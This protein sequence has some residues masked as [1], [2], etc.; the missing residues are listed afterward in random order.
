MKHVGF[1]GTGLIGNP[2]ARRLVGCGFSVRAH[3]RNPQALE[4][5]L[6]A[7]AQR[8]RAPE[9][10]RGVEALLI[11]VNTLEQVRDVLTGEAGLPSALEGGSMP[12]FV[13][14]STV[15]PEGILALAEPLRVRGARLLDAPVSGGPFLAELGRL[16][17]M[18]GGAEEAFQQVRPV[19]EALGD[20][21]F[22]V[23]PLGAGMSAKLVNNMIGLAS[24]LVVPEA[25][26]IGVRAGLNVDRL[27][28]ILNAG[29]GKSFIT[30]N[31][32]MIR[33]FLQAALEEGDPFGARNALFT[34]GRKDLETAREWT[35]GLGI[36]TPVLDRLLDILDA[37]ASGPDSFLENVRSILGLA[38]RGADISSD[39]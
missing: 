6:Q 38:G 31:W 5:V 9:D 12:L 10:F 3:D 8:V 17:V 21:V 33:T 16:S 2:M 11:M 26:K 28:D 20:K 22:H 34:T 13:V 25:L 1:I 23:G 14:M 19:L 4:S 36:S 24:M 18:A 32:A 27:V 37:S 7:G 30:E 29:A 35:S 15:S 39:S